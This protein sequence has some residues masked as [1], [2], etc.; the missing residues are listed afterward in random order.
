MRRTNTTGG[1]S[2]HRSDGWANHAVDAPA[3]GT[4][5]AAVAMLLLPPPLLLLLL[6]ALP[7]PPG[8]PFV[9]GINSGVL[10]AA[11][12]SL[13]ATRSIALS[14]NRPATPAAWLASKQ[15]AARQRLGPRPFRAIVKRPLPMPLPSTTSDAL[16]RPR[17]PRA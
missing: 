17:W 5:A 16:L 6:L 15:M 3:K 2:S 7:L 11:R 9:V 14:R 13:G 4:C 1:A 8:R 12:R 10:L